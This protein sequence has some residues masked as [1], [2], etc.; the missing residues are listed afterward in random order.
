[1]SQNKFKFSC[2]VPAD[3]YLEFSRKAREKSMN[4][5]MRTKGAIT[6]AITEAMLVWLDREKARQE[7]KH[8]YE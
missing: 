1:M 2:Y 4:K 5:D 8:N 6:E 3:L 7:G